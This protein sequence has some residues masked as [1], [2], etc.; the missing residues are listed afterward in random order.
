MRNFRISFF[1]ILCKDPFAVG[2]G[3]DAEILLKSAGKIELIAEAQ[4]LAD[5]ADGYVFPP[6]SLLSSHH[7]LIVDITPQR[8]ANFLPKMLLQG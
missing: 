2:G 4:L 6:K 5:L 1:R 8:G 3:G 7:K